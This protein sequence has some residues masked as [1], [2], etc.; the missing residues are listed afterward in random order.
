MNEVMNIRREST[1]A[2]LLNQHISL[3]A[4]QIVSLTTG[5]CSYHPSSKRLLPTENRYLHRKPQ[6]D[7]VKRSVDG[8]EP[9]PRRYISYIYGPEDTSEE[10]AHECVTEKKKGINLRVERD[11]RG[12]RKKGKGESEL[13]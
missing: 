13:Y 1:I 9:G 2:S 4:L 8:G 3:T 6:L 10:S 7:S 5:K 11:G 12:L